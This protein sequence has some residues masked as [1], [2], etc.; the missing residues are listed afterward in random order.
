MPRWSPNR[1]LLPA[2]TW[3]GGRWFTPYDDLPNTGG[4]RGQRAFGPLTAADRSSEP[5]RRGYRDEDPPRPPTRGRALA[6]LGLALAALLVVAATV[7]IEA[8]LA[9]SGRPTG[10]NSTGLTGNGSGAPSSGTPV[11]ATA[12]TAASTQP[13]SW[14]QV[15]PAYAQRAALAESAPSRMYACGFQGANSQTGPISLVASHD[16]GS[17]WQTLSTPA[18]GAYCDVRVSTTTPQDVA[19][20]A[21]APSSQDG[22]SSTDPN[23]LFLSTD[24]GAHWTAAQ[25]PATSGP[26]PTPPYT[27]AWAGATLFAEA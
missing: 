6:L 26:P 10:R 13:K 22:C 24:G 8:Q 3:I 14:A 19:L 17:T 16:S 9:A 1:T 21:S 5:W 11:S 23:Q 27:V 15:G 12:T 18:K 25:L 7:A 4:T 20:F 2:L